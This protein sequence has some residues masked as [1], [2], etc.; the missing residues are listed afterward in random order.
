[1]Q[2][3]ARPAHL[4]AS[5]FGEILKRVRIERG[6]TQEQLATA[7]GLHRTEISLLE[8]GKRVP[9]LE[10]LVALCY[11]LGMTLAQLLADF[12]IWDRHAL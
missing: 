8:T 1:M 11:G 10:T 3:A 12:E 6:L 5:N 4:L 9:L 7:S 2:Q